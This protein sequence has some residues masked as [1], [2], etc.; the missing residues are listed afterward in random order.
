MSTGKRS[1][2]IAHVPHPFWMRPFYPT[3]R[4]FTVLDSSG[5]VILT[6]PIPLT[7]ARWT[8]ILYPQGISVCAYPFEYPKSPVGLKQS[9]RKKKTSNV[10]VPHAAEPSTYTADGVEVV[11][12]L[13]HN[14][15]YLN[16]CHLVSRK[17]PDDEIILREGPH[18]ALKGFG[19]INECTQHAA[20]FM[21]MMWTVDVT[22]WKCHV[23]P[24]CVCLCARVRCWDFHPI[25]TVI[26]YGCSFSFSQMVQFE[27]SF[28]KSFGAK[29]IAIIEPLCKYRD[30]QT[31]GEVGFLIKNT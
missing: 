6:Q 14:K 29:V 12:T 27:R 26:P 11:R 17:A 5:C 1:A 2:G 25:I 21:C 19:S 23:L 3:A 22:Y 31:C 16:S 28:H 10:R 18:S 4:S 9:K 8:T 7:S 15:V 24:V 20:V 30:L 13:T